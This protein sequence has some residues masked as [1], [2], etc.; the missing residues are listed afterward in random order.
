M[1]ASPLLAYTLKVSKTQ[2]DALAQASGI[3]HA[4]KPIALI[5]SGPAPALAARAPLYATPG[6]S[7]AL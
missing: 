3:R 6:R 7:P 2:N 5:K 1:I 4:G